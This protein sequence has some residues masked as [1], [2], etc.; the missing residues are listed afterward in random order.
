MEIWL[1]NF[2]LFY[3]VNKKQICTSSSNKNELNFNSII[4]KVINVH[5]HGNKL[6]NERLYLSRTQLTF[7]PKDELALIWLLKALLRYGCRADLFIFE[8]IFPIQFV[9]NGPPVP[10]S[11]NL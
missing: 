3:C 6:W 11:K 9:T 1:L 4:Y 5:Q 7:Y 10:A 8:P 2:I